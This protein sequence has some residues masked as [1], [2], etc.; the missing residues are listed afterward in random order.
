MVYRQNGGQLEL[1][2][3][4]MRDFIHR[5]CHRKR[6][7]AVKIRQCIKQADAHV[8]PPAGAVQF[9]KSNAKVVEFSE[10]ALL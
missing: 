10:L 8:T 2:T 6:Q 4:G 5:Q 9:Y 3:Q 1:Q 7:R